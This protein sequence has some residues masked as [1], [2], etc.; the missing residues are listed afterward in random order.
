M[1]SEFADNYLFT[2]DSKLT[3][4]ICT[5][6]LRPGKLTVDYL[7]GQRASQLPPLRT[8]L[9]LALM[10]F[11]IS[12][13]IQIGVPGDSNLVVDGEAKGE[14][15][16][17]RRTLRVGS[18]DP[19]RI[20][21]RWFP[22]ITEQTTRRLH[23]MTDGPFLNE[24]LNS[25]VRVV[26]PNLILALIPVVAGLLAL[27]HRGQ[28]RPLYDHLVFALHFHSGF[29]AMIFLSEV[30]EFAVP[31]FD[32]NWL[33]PIAVLLIPPTSL[34]ALRRVYGGSWTRTL[35]GWTAIMLVYYQFGRWLEDISLLW[36]FLTL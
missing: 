25:R 29:L 12:S 22:E 9:V 2:I 1:V 24:I 28:R 6:L 31:I 35:L 30:I 19:S 18:P 7:G 21:F 32:Q 23:S 10:T 20:P 16:E 8:Y 27:V 11:L 36:V 14:Q 5:L 26:F 4:S 33:T 34:V 13:P 3:R 15:V 17:G